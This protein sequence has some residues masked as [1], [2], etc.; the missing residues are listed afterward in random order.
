MAEDFKV[1]GLAALHEFMQEMPVRL[2]KNILRGAIRAG[3]R[4]VADDAKARAP[5]LKDPDDRRIA[6]AL[7][8]SVRV[9]NVQVKSGT[10]KGGVAAGGKVTVGRGGNKA[11]GDAFY[12][13]FLEYGTVN[14]VPQPF[15]RPAIDG[16]S[17]SAVDASAAYIRQRVEAGDLKK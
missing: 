17:Q 15:M 8:K 13:H 1:D 2:E 4:V 3:A 14:M 6:G 11:D 9:M 7:R 16:K 12:A 10:V 5:V